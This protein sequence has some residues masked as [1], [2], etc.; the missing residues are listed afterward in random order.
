MGR[1]D[2]LLNELM[3]QGRAGVGQADFRIAERRELF[4]PERGPEL[5]L[6]CSARDHD[7]P[8][9]PDSGTNLMKRYA[10]LCGI[11]ARVGRTRAAALLAAAALMFGQTALAAHLCP[12]GISLVTVTAG[13]GVS[14][15]SADHHAGGHQDCHS[16]GDTM[17]AATALC[18]EDCRST[19]TPAPTPAGTAH[20]F[21]PAFVVL[22]PLDPDPAQQA[23]DQASP[24]VPRS[25]AS[26]SR[27][28]P[29]RI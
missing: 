7:I 3:L 23:F 19:D 10:Q 24:S 1:T 16:V 28:L 11:A 2:R 18:I 27:P 15:S 5:R 20:D 26:P 17:P 29:L 13:N 14:S 25:L 22:L 12:P 6:Y 4:G 21:V 9:Q 8:R